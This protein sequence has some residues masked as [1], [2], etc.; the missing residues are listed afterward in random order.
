M[1]FLG[2]INIGDD[3]A[4][5]EGRPGWADLVLELRGDICA[6]LGAKLTGGAST[7]VVG[8]VRIL[9]SG[10]GGGRRLRA[11]YLTA[12][13]HAR[14]KVLYH[15]LLLA[16]VR[17]HEWTAPPCTPRRRWWTSNVCSWAASTWIP[18]RW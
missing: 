4:G 2:G 13:E 8:P 18:S 5:E 3:Y 12:L 10:L 6:R 7:L 15:T 9:L 16:G 14:V 17:I 11:R 1:A